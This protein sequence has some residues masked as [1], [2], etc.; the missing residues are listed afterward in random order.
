VSRKDHRHYDAELRVLREREAL[1][2]SKPPLHKRLWTM[3]LSIGGL[4]SAVVA[5]I[6]F[7]PRVSIVSSSTPLEPDKGYSELLI[8]T[9]TSPLGL[10]LDHVNLKVNVCQLAS[11]PLPFTAAKHWCGSTGGFASPDWQDRTLQA[12]EPIAVSMR[13]FIEL[14]HEPPYTPARLAGA[15]VAFAITFNPWGCPLGSWPCKRT[16]QF[17]FVTRKQDGQI[18]WYS[19][20]LD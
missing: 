2:S 5:A 1:R 11:E 17:R 3:S 4:L 20:P 6:A 7:I 16:K 10:E 19:T 12:D 14:A 13:Q 9:N 15:D 8:I 18:V